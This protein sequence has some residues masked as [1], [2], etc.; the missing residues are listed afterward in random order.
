MFKYIVL[1]TDNKPQHG[2]VPSPL[3][4]TMNPHTG[5]E[6]RDD[7]P[8]RDPGSCQLP[9]SPRCPSC[10]RS[11]SSP[12]RSAVFSDQFGASFRCV[13]L[14]QL[15][16]MERAF[17]GMLRRG[18]RLRHPRGGGRRRRSVEE[19]EALGSK[20][21]EST[22][23]RRGRAA[24]HCSDGEAAA[25]ERRQTGRQLCLPCPLSLVRGHA[26]ACVRAAM[27]VPP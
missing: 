23:E 21:R 9:A 27:H 2:P 1:P 4:V 24:R 5:G 19:E 11:A 6:Y 26:C 16:G 14:P 3:P 25:P 17:A 7:L 15:Q 8:K 18:A 20:A 12:G 22:R 13:L 10:P